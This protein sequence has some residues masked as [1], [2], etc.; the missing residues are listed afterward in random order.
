MG[1][2]QCTRITVEVYT[3]STIIYLVQ[4]PDIGC[5]GSKQGM[6]A[7][8]RTGICRRREQA[9]NWSLQAQQAAGASRGWTFAG[10]RE[11]AGD[12]IKQEMG[13]CKHTG[14]CRRWKQAR[15]ESL[16]AHGGQTF[17][18]A[19]LLQPKGLN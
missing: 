10:T 4:N 5:D 1:Y 17:S 9:G 8:R 16:Q 18:R 7:C 11:Y 15:E 12:G 19:T 3:H 6:G 2:P 13:A 14:I